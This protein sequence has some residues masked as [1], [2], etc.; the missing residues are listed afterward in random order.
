MNAGTF[1][2]PRCE[3]GQGEQAANSTRERH[4]KQVHGKLPKKLLEVH[5][6]A[7][8]PNSA[9]LGAGGMLREW[10]AGGGQSWG[11]FLSNISCSHCCRQN[12]RRTAGLTPQGISYVYIQLISPQNIVKWKH[13]S[14]STPKVTRREQNLF[15][16]KKIWFTTCQR[17]RILIYASIDELKEHFFSDRTLCSSACVTKGFELAYGAELQS[18]MCKIKFIAWQFFF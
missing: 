14:I 18:M 13:C 10:A 11:L 15:I 5:A 6:Q 2:H 3:A 1:S 17:T 12:S 7:H 16:H 8:I 4:G 9:P